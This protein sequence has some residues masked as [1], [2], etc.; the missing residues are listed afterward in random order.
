MIRYVGDGYYCRWSPEYVFCLKPQA[1]PRA[2][3]NNHIAPP[4]KAFPGESGTIFFPFWTVPA[5]VITVM[6]D[7]GSAVLVV[8]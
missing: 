6:S 3:H 7:T 1:R 5:L 4:S 2:N 8:S